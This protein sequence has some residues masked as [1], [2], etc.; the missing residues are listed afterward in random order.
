M[1]FILFFYYKG[2]ETLQLVAQG[3]GRSPIPGED[4]Q[5][6]AGWGSEQC[7]VAV[8]SLFIAGELG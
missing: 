1:I 4:T 7:D 3:G 2:G 6:Q 8:G 5:G